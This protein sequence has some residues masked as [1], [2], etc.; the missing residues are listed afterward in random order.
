MRKVTLGKI[1]GGNG[2]LL[3]FPFTPWA[4]FTV[5]PAVAGGVALIGLALIAAYFVTNYGQI[6][7]FASRRSTFF[8]V[9]SAALG[10][11]ALIALTAVNYIAAK[12]NKTWDLT[13]N[14]IFTLAPQTQST[15]AGLKEKVTAIA[16][17]PADHPY[18]EF[19]QTLLKRYQ[20]QAPDK[21]DYV[22]KDPRK[23]PKL[24]AQYQLKQAETTVVLTR[25]QGDQA[26]HTSVNVIS[27]QD[28]TNALIKLNGVGEQKVYFVVGHG[29]W[30]SSRSPRSTTSP[31]RRTRRGI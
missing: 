10:V 3:L 21:F 25:G 12:K 11:A 2:L 20:S 9:S 18:L 30:P 19:V 6:G 22:F 29:E 1:L 24:A 26:P 5:S 15:L 16:F 23:E 13:Q 27:E 28:L 8:I 17:L 14:K 7:Q 4:Y 31:R